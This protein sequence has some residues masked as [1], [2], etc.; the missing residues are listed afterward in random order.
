[1]AGKIR[2]HSGKIFIFCIN[3]FLMMIAVFVIKNKDQAKRAVETQK[4]LLDENSYLKNELQSLK[5]VL[6]E[7]NSV[8]PAG[9]VNTPADENTAITPSVGAENSVPAVVSAPTPVP[10]TKNPANARTKTS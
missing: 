8:L 5:G 10:T 2:N 7:I 6:N 4:N 1:M 3:L 9:N